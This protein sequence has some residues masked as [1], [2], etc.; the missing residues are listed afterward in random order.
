MRTRPIMKTHGGKYYHCD[1]IIK[2]FPAR[3][4]LMDYG[5]PFVGG[6]SVFLSKQRGDREIINDVDYPTY[7]VYICLRDRPEELIEGLRNLEYRE[8]EYLRL[9]D[10]VPNSVLDYAIREYGLRNMSRGGL[11]TSGFADQE[12]LRGG[13]PGDRNAWETGLDRLSHLSDRLQ[14]V[15]ITNSDFDHV[16]TRATRTWFLYLDPPYLHETRTS[17]CDYVCEMS[18]H[19]HVRLLKVI[20]QSDA[21]I[22]ISGY[23]SN[24]YK[25]HLDGWKCYSKLVANSASQAETKSERKECIWMNY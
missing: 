19:D 21:K 9:R 18:E 8:G 16:I 2:Y 15:E 14:G 25:L 7:C 12:R 5:E 24:L 4:R 20:T 6:G 22:M 23:L 11:R 1:W 3:Y 17:T 10:Q 13:I